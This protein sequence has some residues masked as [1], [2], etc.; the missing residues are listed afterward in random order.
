MNSDEEKDLYKITTF[1]SLHTLQDI[2][3]KIEYEL[4]DQPKE[5]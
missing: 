3:A 1:W 4:Q 2:K 5:D